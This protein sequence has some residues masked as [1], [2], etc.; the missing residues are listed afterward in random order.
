MPVD[1]G[2]WSG[3][4]SL[5]EVEQKP[6]H[7]LRVKYGSVEIDELGKVL[8]PTQVSRARPRARGCGRTAGSGRASCVFALAAPIGASPDA[9]AGEGGPCF[10]V[11]SCTGAGCELVRMALNSSGVAAC[12]GHRAPPCAAQLAG[13]GSRAGCS[14]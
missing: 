10:A 1:L 8:T 6:A 5:T 12:A 13:A 9:G 14:C 4:L 2:L 3:P 11:G 7:P